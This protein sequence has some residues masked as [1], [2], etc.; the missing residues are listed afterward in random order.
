M[1]V[2]RD[3]YGDFHV[4]GTC[5]EGEQRWGIQV[6]KGPIKTVRRTTVTELWMANLT[7]T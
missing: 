4:R 3:D 2:E 1:T 6:W 7:A 5:D